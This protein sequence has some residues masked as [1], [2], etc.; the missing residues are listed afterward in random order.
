MIPWTDE[1]WKN[2]VAAGNDGVLYFQQDENLYKSYDDGETLTGPTLISVGTP[3]ESCHEYWNQDY[4]L[5]MLSNG[6]LYSA[7]MESRYEICIPDCNYEQGWILHLSSNDGGSTWSSPGKIPT[8][9]DMG[10]NYYYPSLWVTPS[11]KLHYFYASGCCDPQFATGYAH[12]ISADNAQS[13]STAVDVLSL[14]VYFIIPTVGDDDGLYI[15]NRTEGAS[16]QQINVK[17]W[18]DGAAA[19][20][21]TSN[22]VSISNS[23]TVRSM[24]VCVDSIGNI[25]L[26]YT[27]GPNDSGYAVYYQRSFDRGVTWTTS[28]KISYLGYITAPNSILCDTAGNLYLIWSKTSSP[29]PIYFTSSDRNQ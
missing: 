9:V 13:W 26:F 17:Y 16:S 22:A 3:D 20:S 27:Y 8:H 21:A 4:S 29:Y 12:M 2:M 6:K 7:W 24:A 14:T 11:G 19:P 1:Q 25:N 28:Q 23:Q 18:I 5:K 10:A 15:P